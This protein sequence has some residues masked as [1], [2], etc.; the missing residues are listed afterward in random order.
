MGDVLTLVEKAQ[1]EVEIAD[2]EIMQKKLQEAT[3]DFSDFVK[4]MRM[5]KRMGSL[6]GLLKMIPGMNKID[7][8]MIK[9]GEDQLKKIEAMIGSMSEEERNKP[10]LLAAQPSRRRRVASGSGH[11]PADVDKV[12]A[13]FQRMRGLMKQMSTGGGLPGMDGGLPG[14]GGLPSMPSSGSNPYQAR[15]GRGGAGSAP[16]RQRPVKKKKGFGDL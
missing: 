11:Q 3:F 16:R 15:K 2:A 7:D 14:M 12:L 4:Q 13:D 8:G 6:G 10:E 1:K 5:I 9:S